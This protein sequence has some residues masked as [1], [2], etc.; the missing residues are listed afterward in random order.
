MMQCQAWQLPCV[1]R[2][3]DVAHGNLEQEAR[4]A[5]YQA[6]FE[7]IDHDE[8]LVLGHHQQDQAETVF[9]RLMSGS[10]VVGLSA[11][12]QHELR[13]QHTLWRPWLGVSRAQV[14]ELATLICPDF[15]NDPANN[16]LR[17]DR[18]ILRQQVWPILQ[19][20][21]PSFEQGMARSAFLMQ[22]AADILQDVLQIDWANCV[23]QNTLD[24]EQFL[25]LSEPRQRWL[26]SKWMQQQE[27]YAPSLQLVRRIKHEL[28][29]A[30]PDAKPKVDWGNWQF[31]RYRQL[32]YRLPNVLPQ[33]TNLQ[34]KI[35]LRDEL[36]LPSGQ[37]KI[38]QHVN[39]FPLDLLHKPVNLLARE[40]GEI[41]HLR[42]AIGHR[43][44]KKTLQEAQLAPWQREQVHLLQID[45]VIYGVLT[46]TG[47][48]PSEKVPWVED[49]WLPCLTV[50]STANGC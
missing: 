4:K 19:T 42:G 27:Q 38:Q 35:A 8:V 40:G 46:A 25:L 3:V 41:L 14:T 17:F 24:I 29:E 47:F 34:L 30:K 31:R 28:I 45:G 5:R 7:S 16:D 10:G 20:R 12:Q 36:D 50:G 9:M 39:G 48:W 1:I 15:I 49:G 18:V 11:M 37:W 6:I 33:A 44:L 26:L 43:P 13:G 23:Q 21:W 22:D 2:A 32:I